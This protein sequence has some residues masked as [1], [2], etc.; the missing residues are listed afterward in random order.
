LKKGTGLSSFPRSIRLSDDDLENSFFVGDVILDKLSIPLL[1]AG[2]EA[3]RHLCD[4]P[5]AFLDVGIH[6]IPLDLVLLGH[7]SFDDD[8]VGSQID[9]NI[10]G[11]RQK[12]G[13]ADGEFGAS[14]SL[15]HMTTWCFPSKGLGGHAFARLSSSS[16]DHWS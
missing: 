2:P 11:M 13:S 8:L 4:C 1:L 16:T 7:G 9:D 10:V 15:L 5:I 12:L 6:S 3:L 14:L